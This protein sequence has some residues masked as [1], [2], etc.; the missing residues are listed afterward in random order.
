MRFVLILLILL[1]VGIGGG[2]FVYRARHSSVP[3]VPAPKIYVYT[4]PTYGYSFRRPQSWSASQSNA[5]DTSQTASQRDA[6]IVFS[7]DGQSQLTV[8]VTDKTKAGDISLD[9]FA[10]DSI[11]P[12]DQVTISDKTAYKV[13][14][15][16]GIREKVV[17]TDP[18]YSGLVYFTQDKNYFYT[19]Y[20]TKSYELQ[21]VVVALAYFQPKATP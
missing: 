2:V 19:F 12:K 18:G 21:D 9:Q 14:G 6:A 15:L 3:T 1:L 5:R 10:T 4:N 8:Q 20:T 16:D 7:R 17:I 11:T 13:G